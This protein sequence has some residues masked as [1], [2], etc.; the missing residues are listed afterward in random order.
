MDKKAQYVSKGS[1]YL[2]DRK[3]HEFDQ[4][5]LES[6]TSVQVRQINSITDKVSDETDMDIL[7]IFMNHKNLFK[8]IRKSK[9]YSDKS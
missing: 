7:D 2:L 6:G 5:I 4:E 3:I 1:A 9:K 8:M